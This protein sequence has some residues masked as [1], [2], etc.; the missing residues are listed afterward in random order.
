VLFEPELG[1][2]FQLSERV[3]VE[4]TWVHASHAQLLSRQNPGLDSIGIEQSILKRFGARPALVRA[5][6]NH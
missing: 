6:V 4:A 3:A 2:G 1:L 5:A